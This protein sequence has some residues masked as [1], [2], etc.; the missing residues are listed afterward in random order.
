[1]LNKRV[2]SRDENVKGILRPGL[3]KWA[4]ALSQKAPP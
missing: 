3:K 2:D 1:M 4:E